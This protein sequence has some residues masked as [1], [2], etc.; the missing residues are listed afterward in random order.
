MLRLFIRN[1]FLAVSAVVS[2]F[3]FV[4]IVEFGLNFYAETLLLKAKRSRRL[5]SRPFF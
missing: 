2:C 3:F 4:E 5:K 1:L